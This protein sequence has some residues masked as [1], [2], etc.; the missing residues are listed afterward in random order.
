M[1][2]PI[3]AVFSLWHFRES[4]TLAQIIW[5]MCM[6]NPCTSILVCSKILRKDIEA[7]DLE[8][9]SLHSK[10]T[11]H[12]GNGKV[13]TRD[14]V[15]ATWKEAIRKIHA[16]ERAGALTP[17]ESNTS[18]LKLQP[19]GVLISRLQGVENEL[20]VALLL[21]SSVIKPLTA[22]ELAAIFSALAL[23][24]QQKKKFVPNKVEPLFKAPKRI[25]LALGKLATLREEALALQGF[26]NVCILVPWYLNTCFHSK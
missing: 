4:K 21:T 6:L 25:Q 23:N 1:W 15:G 3:T 7:V 8:M 9:K 22:P 11:L 24:E 26:D 12:H 19:L 10:V 2:L 16:L 20:W 5:L 18:L 14:T 17:C 13:E